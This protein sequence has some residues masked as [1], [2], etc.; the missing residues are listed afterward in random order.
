MKFHVFDQLVH[1]ILTKRMN[2][3]TLKTPITLWGFSVSLYY[4]IKSHTFPQVTPFNA[5]DATAFLNYAAVQKV[6]SLARAASRGGLLDENHLHHT[7]GSE[8]LSPETSSARSNSVS[9]SSTHVTRAVASLASSAV[10]QAS[11]FPEDGA[12][13]LTLAVASMQLTLQQHRREGAAGG[14]SSLTGK[15]D[16]EQEEDG[17]DSGCREGGCSSTGRGSSSDDRVVSAVSDAVIVVSLEVSRFVTERCEGRALLCLELMADL[18]QARAL[19]L[20]TLSTTPTSSSSSSGTPTSEGSTAAAAASTNTP[21]RFVVE[22]RHGTSL[23]N[24]PLSHQLRLRALG[25]FH[26]AMGDDTSADWLLLARLASAFQVM[27]GSSALKLLVS[28]AFSRDRKSV[29]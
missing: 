14:L 21:M 22:V 26:A 12:R 25:R 4:A 13:L 3:K 10:A 20:K 29:V 7:T 18:F 1:F 5:S 9:G 19:E 8:T 16:G 11:V 6:A 27:S 28:C 24:L 23:D 17:T 2:T 15:R